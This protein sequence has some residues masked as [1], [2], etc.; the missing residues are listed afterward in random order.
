MASEFLASVTVA[1]SPLTEREEKGR[2]RFGKAK[3]GVQLRVLGPP[4]HGHTEGMN[5]R[6]MSKQMVVKIKRLYRKRAWS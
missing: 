6:L 2:N 4:R 5:L 3:R 1:V